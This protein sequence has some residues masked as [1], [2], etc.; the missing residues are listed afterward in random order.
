VEGDQV[1]EVSG[2]Y[3]VRGVE[4]FAQT[5]GVCCLCSR[6][7][8][9]RPAHRSMLVDWLIEGKLYCE[10]YTFTREL[11]SQFLSS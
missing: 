2:L 11:T 7:K 3:S 9:L 4:P 5:I 1:S 8:T 6:Q 10:F